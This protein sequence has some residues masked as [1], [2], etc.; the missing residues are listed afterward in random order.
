MDFDR[1]RFVSERADSREVLL[2]VEIPEQTGAFLNLYKI[3]FPP[4]NVTGT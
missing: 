3:L 1:L 4:R 2:A